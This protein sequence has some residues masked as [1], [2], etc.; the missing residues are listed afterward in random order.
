MALLT[1]RNFRGGQAGPLAEAPPAA[2]QAGSRVWPRSMLNKPHGAVI[3]KHLTEHRVHWAEAR[4]VIREQ[5]DD[6]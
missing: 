4:R 3:L 1:V 6:R 2:G 5:L